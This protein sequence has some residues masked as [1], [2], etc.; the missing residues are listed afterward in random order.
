MLHLQ[1]KTQLPR[2]DRQRYRR[3]RIFQ[4]NAVGKDRDANGADADGF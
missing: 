3:D 2:R 4:K 1:S